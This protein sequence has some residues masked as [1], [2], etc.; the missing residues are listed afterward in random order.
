MGRIFKRKGSDNW[1]LDYT[2][3]GQRFRPCAETSDR[4][5]AEALLAK[6]EHEAF[7]GKHFPTVEGSDRTLEQLRD[8]WLALKSE[9]KTIAKDAEHFTTLIR[10]LGANKVCRTLTTADI[11]DLRSKLAHL[12]PASFN[13][14]WEVLRAALRKAKLPVPEFQKLAENNER[15]LV[16]TPDQFRKLMRNASPAFKLLLILGYHTGQRQGDIRRWRWDQ[17]DLDRGWVQ[18]KDAKTG[19]DHLVP[20]NADAL[21]ALKKWPRTGER[22]F[23]WSDKTNLSQY[24]RRLRVSAGLPDLNFH[25]LRHTTATRLR[26]AGTDIPTIMELLGHKSERTARRYQT[27][28]KPELRRAVAN[29]TR[30]GKGGQR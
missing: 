18:T 11:L 12:K 19:F 27:I 5:L 7:L 23:S 14:I 17:V 1:Y 28:E 21:A 24:Q 26:Q 2:A 29:L 8:F 10:Y 3:N 6:R 30:V 15:K 20:L 22:I 16:Y 25:D 13:R 4:K 9:K